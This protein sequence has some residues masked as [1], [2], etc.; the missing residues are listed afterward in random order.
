GAVMRDQFLLSSTFVFSM[1]CVIVSFFLAVALIP[2]LRRV[3]PQVGL[4]DRPGG[5]KHHDGAVP[6]VGGV[7]ISLAVVV[8]SLA[9]GVVWFQVW[10]LAVAWVA[11]LAFGIWDDRRAVRNAVKFAIQIAVAVLIVIGEAETIRRVAHTVIGSGP[12]WHVVAYTIAL[13]FI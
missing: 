1:S 2:M 12:M 6:L 10:N 4:V 8:T 5:R 11:L 3:A 7:G 9:V 13:L